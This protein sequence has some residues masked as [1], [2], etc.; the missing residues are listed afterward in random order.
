MP[1]PGAKQNQSERVSPVL[2][3]R[4]EAGRSAGCMAL[5]VVHQ[6]A[7]GT[8]IT[9]T[10]LARRKRSSFESS[11]N[12]F[13]DKCPLSGVQ[14]IGRLREETIEKLA[15][16]NLTLTGRKPIRTKVVRGRL[17]C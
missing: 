7:S 6:R 8:G 9:N 16:W 15:T 3:L 12:R 10:A 13:A 4:C 14:R 2:R 5:G 17:G 11:L 1:H